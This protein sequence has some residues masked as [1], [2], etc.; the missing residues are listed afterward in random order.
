MITLSPSKVCRLTDKG[1]ELALRHYKAELEILTDAVFTYHPD[2][3]NKRNT[4]Q[5]QRQFVVDELRYRLAD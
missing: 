4:I 1:L 3:P 2:T 5:Q